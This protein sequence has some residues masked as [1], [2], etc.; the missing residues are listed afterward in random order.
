MIDEKTAFQLTQ[1]PESTS[2]DQFIFKTIIA[3]DKTFI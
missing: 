2:Y 1:C 3:K